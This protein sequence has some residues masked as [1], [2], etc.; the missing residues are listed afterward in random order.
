MYLFS[1]ND[2]TIEAV[3]IKMNLLLNILLVIQV[4]I[5]ACYLLF[6]IYSHIIEYMSMG[7]VPGVGE[8]KDACGPCP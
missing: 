2:L 4:S 5:I 1:Y 3:E 7:Y 8:K 6:L